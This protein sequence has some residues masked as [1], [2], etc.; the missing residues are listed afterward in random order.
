MSLK[1][2][3][4]L[5]LPQIVESA[6]ILLQNRDLKLA[7]MILKQLPQEAFNHHR[8]VA[9]FLR[10]LVQSGEQKQ[11]E[12]FASEIRRT[13][14]VL[15][16][17]DLAALLN[18]ILAP[19]PDPEELPH[20]LVLDYEFDLQDGHYS[21][22]MLLE[23]PF[24]GSAYVANTGWGIM[25]LRPAV[26][27]ACLKPSLISPEFLVEN[28]QKFHISDGNT[29]LREIDQQIFRTVGSWHLSDDFPMEGFK[30]GINLAEPLMLR[31]QRLLVRNIYL[32]KHVSTKGVTA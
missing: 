9:I 20:P 25:I 28:F 14:F 23:C 1:E 6:D 32:E 11:A 29:G 26:C 27:Y 18:Q 10:Y 12:R 4:P 30:D 31:I 21:T 2:G 17:K 8:I 16:D 19:L 24:C 15:E 22:T 5:S 13:N 7:Q 3:N